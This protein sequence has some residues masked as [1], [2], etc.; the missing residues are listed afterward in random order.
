MK[1]LAS[2][3]LCL[4]LSSCKVPEAIEKTIESAKR[5]MG[6]AFQKTEAP[7]PTPTPVDPQSIV[8]ANAELLMEMMTVVYHTKGPIDESQ[9]KSLLSTLNQGASLEGVYRGLVMGSRYR[10]LESKSRAASPQAIKFFAQ[11]MAELQL[12]MQNPTRFD[13][14][15]A[16][17]FP[18]IEYPEGD[19]SA[20][21]TDASPAVDPPKPTRSELT[22]N[23]LQLFLGATPY[24]LKRVLAEEAL[25]KMEEMATS[26]GELAQW[27]TTLVN[28]VSASGV[29]FGLPLRNDPNA[30]F[31]FKF[32]QN[33]PVD[34]VMWEVLNRYHRILNSLN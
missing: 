20:T 11:E 22:E 28:R 25:K 33:S 26:H 9:F 6:M 21:V 12:S 31:H 17:A 7:V 29:D 16:K 4:M 3:L 23:F 18:S 5:L 19:E 13:R 24:T 1:I 10:V 30:E 27:Y 8:K 2:L 14:E 32:A 15:N 34:R